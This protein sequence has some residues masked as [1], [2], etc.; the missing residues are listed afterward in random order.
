MPN[1]ILKQKSK[2][3]RRDSHDMIQLMAKHGNHIHNVILKSDE[4]VKRYLA[5]KKIDYE[6]LVEHCRIFANH[7]PIFENLIGSTAFTEGGGQISR[8]DFQTGKEDLVVEH[9][10][11]LALL[12]YWAVF[13]SSIKAIHRAMDEN[14]YFEFLSGIT[15]GISSIEGYINYRIEKWNDSNPNTKSLNFKEKKLSIED[16]IDE[17]LPQIANKQKFNKG[18]REWEAFT[19]LRRIRDD[20]GVHP[21]ETGYAISLEDLA[22]KINLFKT[23][24]AGILVQLHL[25]FD[26]RIPSSIIRAMFSPEVE[27][28]KE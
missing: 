22:S 19:K 1:Y 15:Q 11:S 27:V 5:D 16:K 13:D 4:D 3:P 8:Y 26:D 17:W 24:I 21:K 20:E 28:L 25:Y 9:P 14:S 6:N 18:I 2:I 12:G 23:G 10:G 7:V